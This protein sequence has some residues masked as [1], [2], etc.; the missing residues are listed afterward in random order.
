MVLTINICDLVKRFDHEVILNHINLSIPLNSETF[1]LEG[2]NGAGKSTF[3]KLLCGLVLPDEGEIKLSSQKA[4]H[5]WARENTYYLSASDRGLIYRLTG[6]DNI[7]YI[8]ALKGKR[9]DGYQLDY[10]CD[11]FSCKALLYKRA[12][13]MS[14]GEKKK[15]QLLGALM[16]QMQFILLDEPSS[17]LDRQSQGAL[18]EFLNDSVEAKIGVISHDFYFSQQLVGEHYCICERQ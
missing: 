15:I 11:L 1:I 6:R 8:L 17:F 4:Y 10:L 16:S 18:C 9:P 2:E 5:A 7:H 13:Q 12:Y 14:S 3:F